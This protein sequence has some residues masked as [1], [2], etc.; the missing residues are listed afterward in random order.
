MSQISFSFSN[1]LV[2]LQ[3]NMLSVTMVWNSHFALQDTRNFTRSPPVGTAF[4]FTLDSNTSAQAATML[5]QDPNLRKM[6]FQL[7]PKT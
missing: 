2:S 4:T 3:G 5:E 6:R 1:N 7:V